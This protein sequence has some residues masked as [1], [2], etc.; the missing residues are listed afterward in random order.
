MM[1][2]VILFQPTPR[3]KLGVKALKYLKKGQTIEDQVMVDVLVEA[4]R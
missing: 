2:F 1:S 4:I 3:N